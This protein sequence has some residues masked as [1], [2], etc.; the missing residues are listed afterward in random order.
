MINLKVNKV[1]TPEERRVKTIEQLKKMGIDYNPHLP[2]LE[3][4][5]NVKLK[6]A[7]EVKKR[8]LGCMLC[9]QLAWSI[10]NGENYADSLLFVLQYLDK[11]KVSIDDLLPKERLLIQN[12]NTKSDS[13]DEFT[14]QDIIDIVWTYEVYWSLIWVLDLITDKELKNATNICNTERAMAISGLMDQLTARLRN[15]EKIFINKNFN[16]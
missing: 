14:K 6:S 13:K 15:V 3:S 12:K 2:L 11:W 9:V 7:K 5:E 1:I 16:N 4:S 10:R 8:A